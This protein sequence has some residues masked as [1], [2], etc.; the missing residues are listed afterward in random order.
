MGFYNK[1]RPLD[2]YAYKY[3][4]SICYYMLH[5]STTL[6]SINIVKN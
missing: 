6:I 4:H 1:L 5:I 3:K 2:V